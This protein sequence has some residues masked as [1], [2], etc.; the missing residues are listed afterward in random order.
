MWKG[1]AVDGGVGMGAEEGL[2]AVRVYA[3]ACDADEGIVLFGI[4]VRILFVFLIMM[5]MI[6]VLMVV[7]AF[8]TLIILLEIIIA[9]ILIFIIIICI[10]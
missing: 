10:L 1:D 3:E 4:V 5:V 2:G 8:V 6:L 7:Y 9:W